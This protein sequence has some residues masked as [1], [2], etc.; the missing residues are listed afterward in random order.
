M[1]N[2]PSTTRSNKWFARITVPHEFAKSKI[3]DVLSWIDLTSL[4]VATHVGERNEGEHIHLVVMLTSNLQKQSFDVRLKNLYGVKGNAFYSS[5][6]WDGNDS[7]CSYLF[8]DPNAQIIAN[9]GYTESDLDR[10]RKLNADVQKVIAINK[11]RA[12]NRHADKLV[13][14]AGETGVGLSRYA[15]YKEIMRRVREGEMYYPGE[16]NLK[17]LVEEVYVRILTDDEFSSYLPEKFESLFR[18]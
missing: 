16:Y 14:W 2:M 17:K 18:T 3:N 5:K 15:I 12:S 1:S 13:E 4:L 11:D 10:F 7:A 6:P 8:H 9:K